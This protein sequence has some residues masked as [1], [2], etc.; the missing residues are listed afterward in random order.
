M[1]DQPKNHTDQPD[2]TTGQRWVEAMNTAASEANITL[3]FC[4]M[5]PVHTLATT[6]LSAVTNGRATRDD[7]AGVQRNQPGNGLVLGISG[8]LH[9]ALGSG[10]AVT[11]CGPT[12]RRAVGWSTSPWLR[13]K[14]SS[15]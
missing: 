10:P 8:M 15:P 5:D 7:H 4:M 11:M 13:R 3:Q 9:Y 12:P 1:L 2:V 6:L 14:R